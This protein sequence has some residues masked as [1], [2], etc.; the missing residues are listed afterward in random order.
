MLDFPFYAKECKLL[1]FHLHP[2]LPPK[3]GSEW[4]GNKIRKRCKNN[5]SICPA[6]FDGFCWPEKKHVC[7]RVVYKFLPY[8]GGHTVSTDCLCFSFLYSELE[9]PL[10]FLFFFKWTT[11]FILK[12]PERHSPVKWKANTLCWN[13]KCVEQKGLLKMFPKPVS[14]IYTFNPSGKD[15]M[16]HNREGQAFKRRD[17]TG[18][19]CLCIPIG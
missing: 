13:V 3:S 5:N 11:E 6:A 14:W 18:S 17:W 10:K 12:T 2:Q 7:G 19:F 8:F 9:K 15:S 1:C 16:H 4:K